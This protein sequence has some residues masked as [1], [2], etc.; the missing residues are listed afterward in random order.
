VLHIDR[1]TDEL[2]SATAFR[3]TDQSDDGKERREGSRRIPSSSGERRLETSSSTHFSS[4]LILKRRDEDFISNGVRER[5]TT[6]Q[7][8][9]LEF[10][11]G[12]AISIW[13]I[14]N[15]SISHQRQIL[16]RGRGKNVL[17]KFFF[18][19]FQSTPES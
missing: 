9:A 2:R 11:H 6:S 18:A 19:H 8:E 17:K 5:A 12:D 1:G 3:P 4:K 15:C 13:N 10:V 16:S 14:L 7:H